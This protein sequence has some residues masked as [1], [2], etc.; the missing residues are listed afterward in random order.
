MI[1]P[2]CGWP[3]VSVSQ[4]SSFACTVSGVAANAVPIV[5]T[6]NVAATNALMHF[7]NMF[8]IKESL[9]GLL[10]VG[11][12]FCYLSVKFAAGGKNPAC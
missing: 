2:V 3:Y 11:E 12:I 8:F 7:W 9:L 4:R 10:V 6:R 1:A 5:E